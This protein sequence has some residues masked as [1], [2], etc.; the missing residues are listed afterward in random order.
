MV[1]ILS[2]SR[3]PRQDW[4]TGAGPPSAGVVSATWLRWPSPCCAPAGVVS[5]GGN[6]RRQVGPRDPQLSHL[7]FC[8]MHTG[9]LVFI[10][11]PYIGN[12]SPNWLIF[13]RGLK[14]PIRLIIIN[15]K[16]LPA[17]LRTVF[18]ET[19]ATDSQSNCIEGWWT[20][21]GSPP[22]QARRLES[23]GPWAI[24]Q[25]SYLGGFILREFKES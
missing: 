22:A 11:F 2:S 25:L 6:F 3:H 1:I 9:W 12:N 19:T 18:G 23:A 16:I 4:T 5:V 21:R 14:P 20:E 7:C 17:T 10:G 13:F 24:S 15:Y 8:S